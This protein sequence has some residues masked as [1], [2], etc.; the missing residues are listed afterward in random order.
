MFVMPTI[1]ETTAANVRAELARRNLTQADL[2]EVLDIS[3]AQVSARLRGRARLHLG[4]VA[5]IAAFLD[6]PVSDLVPF[7]DVTA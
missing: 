1:E 2:A 7:E 3:Q 6:V 4:E 5:L